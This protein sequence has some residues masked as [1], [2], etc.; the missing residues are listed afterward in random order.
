MN[1]RKLS[2]PLILIAVLYL[3]GALMYFLVSLVLIFAGKTGYVPP[4]LTGSLSN[5]LIILSGFVFLAIAL[6]YFFVGKDL[7]RRKNWA[8]TAAIVISGIS[9][10]F[11][12]YSLITGSIVSAVMLVI[13]AAIVAYFLLNKE[14]KKNFS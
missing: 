1:E 9:A 13:N 11:N 6:L 10:L 8:R 5:G 2:A 3:L 14:A 12:L 4:E 7:L